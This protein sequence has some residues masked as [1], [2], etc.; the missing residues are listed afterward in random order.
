MPVAAVDARRP[1]YRGRA[2]IDP[3][4]RKGFC[5]GRGLGGDEAHIAD[6]IVPGACRDSCGL[7]RSPGLRIRLSAEGLAAALDL[8]E[9][10][11]HEISLVHHHGAGVSSVQLDAGRRG[12]RDCPRGSVPDLRERVNIAL[13]Q[14][15]FGYRLAQGEGACVRIERLHARVEL[16]VLA[17]QEADPLPDKLARVFVLLRFVGE[18]QRSGGSVFGNGGLLVT[19]DLASLGERGRRCVCIHL[20]DAA[21]ERLIVAALA[22]DARGVGRGHR[23]GIGVGLAEQVEVRYGCRR[24]R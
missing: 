21:V 16:L 14:A 19:A 17:R 7:G 8:G 1:G 9:R 22:A 6:S 3:S 13:G 24:R 2:R 5:G 12:R 4:I 18:R 11:D 20:H 10:G 23:V 15:A